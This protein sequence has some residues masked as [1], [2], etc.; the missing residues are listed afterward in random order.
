MEEASI[1][2]FPRLH[3]FEASII[4]KYCTASTKLSILCRLNSSWHSFIF[5]GYAWSSLLDSAK[6]PT[7]LDDIGLNLEA[8][9]ELLLDSHNSE[10]VAQLLKKFSHFEGL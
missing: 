10:A 4:A 3:L 5:C 6:D 8:F 7:W 2:L 9:N 1:P